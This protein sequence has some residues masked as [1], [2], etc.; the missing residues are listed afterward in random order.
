M[1]YLLLSLVLLFGLSDVT[2]GQSRF[3]KYSK[4]LKEMAANKERVKKTGRKVVIQHMKVISKVDYMSGKYKKLI[5]P[6]EESGKVKSIQ[7]DYK[8]GR[9]IRVI[10]RPRGQSI[11]V[12]LK[13]DGA[14]YDYWKN[15]GWY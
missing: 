13:S 6:Y 9:Y 10:Q 3:E 7:S 15:K 2:F 8:N 4:L 1:K 14:T 12:N 5:V 11:T